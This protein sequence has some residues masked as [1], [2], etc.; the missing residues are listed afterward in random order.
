M[1]LMKSISPSFFEYTLFTAI[2]APRA[3][4][5]NPSGCVHMAYELSRRRLLLDT[6]RLGS[7]RIGSILDMAIIK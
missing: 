2:Y 6:G 5:L 4:L 1:N 3:D 7:L